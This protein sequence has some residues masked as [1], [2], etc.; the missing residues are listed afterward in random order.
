MEV[1]EEDKARMAKR[2]NNEYKKWNNN[3]PAGI[4]PLESESDMEKEW[5]FIF[6]PP[7]GSYYHGGKWKCKLKMDNY[8]FKAPK[9]SF[10]DNIYH[11]N[12]DKEGLLCQNVYET[13]WAPTQN[14]FDIA[15][16]LSSVM[17]DIDTQNPLNDDAA[18]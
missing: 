17:I 12:V 13:D 6:S 11:P 9:L 5:V 14:T 16:K 3:P 10:V 15:K 4:K 1:R 8:P 7:E 2:V 18:K